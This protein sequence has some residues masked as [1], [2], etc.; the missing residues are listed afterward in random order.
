MANL[1]INELLRFLSVQ[2]DKM[3]RDN[4]ISVLLDSYSY[5]AALDAK[6]VLISECEKVSIVESIGDFTVKRQ[7]GKSG[8]LSRVITDTV[9]IWT[10]VD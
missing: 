6:T 8:A 4:L 1:L 3:T 2:F 7:A 5:R 10:V 9:D